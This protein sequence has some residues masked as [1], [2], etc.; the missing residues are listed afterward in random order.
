MLLLLL[1]LARGR[2]WKKAVD[3]FVDVCC[4][5]KSN[6]HHTCRSLSPRTYTVGRPKAQPFRTSSCGWKRLHSE[7][8]QSHGADALFLL[9]SSHLGRPWPHSRSS[10]RQLCCPS[11]HNGSR[12][13]CA[14][15]H[16]NRSVCNR[17][18]PSRTSIL[19]PCIAVET[20]QCLVQR[21]LWIEQRLQHLAQHTQ[22][23]VQHTQRP[24]QHV[25][26]LSQRARRHAQNA[27]HCDRQRPSRVPCWR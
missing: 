7:G 8:H 10:F 4:A 9:F 5:Q 23:P 18:V 27:Q 15:R 11:P 14:S 1:T 16:R 12:D 20:Q 19:R 6:D 3:P 17:A 2:P 21:V 24:A 26:H 22:R 25:R 13:H